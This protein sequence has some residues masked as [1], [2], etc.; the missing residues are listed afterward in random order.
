MRRRFAGEHSI[1]VAM[2]ELDLSYALTMSGTYDEAA[3]LARDAVRS[4]RAKFGDSNSMVF[5]AQIH[6][7]DALRGQGKYAEAEPLLLAAHKRFEVPKPITRGWRGSAVAALVRLYEAKGRPDE[8][9][10]Y[11]ALLDSPPR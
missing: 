6:L 4:L 5:F 9:A 3:S 7:G 2:T 1:D 8:A 11:R 10:K